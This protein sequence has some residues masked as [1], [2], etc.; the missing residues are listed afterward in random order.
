MKFTCGSCGGNGERD[1]TIERYAERFGPKPP[2]DWLCDECWGKT[3]AGA[4]EKAYNAL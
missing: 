3:K 4:R 2:K 1:M